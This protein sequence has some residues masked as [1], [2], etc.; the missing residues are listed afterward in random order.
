MVNT[1]KMLRENINIFRTPDYY[2]SEVRNAA[3][4]RLLVTYTAQ[5]YGTHLLK[6]YKI[7]RLWF[8]NLK[9]YMDGPMSYDMLNQLP[10]I[11]FTYCNKLIK[12]TNY[13]TKN[14]SI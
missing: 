13:P 10:H 5:Y 9:G 3:S 12:Q 8:T 14:G 4:V 6:K 1:V 7:Q 2:R 11:I